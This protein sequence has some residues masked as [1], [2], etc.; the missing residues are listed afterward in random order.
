MG[1]KSNMFCFGAKKCEMQDDCEEREACRKAVVVEPLRYYF[2]EG[3]ECQSSCEMVQNSDGDYIKYADYRTEREALRERVR[4]LEGA[5]MH[6]CPV[7]GCE[8]TLLYVLGNDDRSCAE[9]SE[10]GAEFDGHKL[11][12][13]YIADL[14][15]E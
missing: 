12:V 10:C 1:E 6:Y 13:L 8:G 9:C 11:G 7:I 5:F 4:E 2:A 3:Y 15:K 14:D